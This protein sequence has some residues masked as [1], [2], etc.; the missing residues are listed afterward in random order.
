MIQLRRKTTITLAMIHAATSPCAAAKPI[1]TRAARRATGATPRRTIRGESLTIVKRHAA[2]AL[3][4]GR[5]ASTGRVSSRLTA[6][7]TSRC[8][9]R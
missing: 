3:G 4:Q 8:P 9:S 2:P 6:A 7:R 5:R 1:P